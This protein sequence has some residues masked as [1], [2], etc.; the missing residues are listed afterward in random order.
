MKCQR[1]GI[2]D[3]VQGVAFRARA[4]AGTP[5]GSQAA[6]AVVAPAR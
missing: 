1:P 4:R 2:G 3:R 5:R 6:R